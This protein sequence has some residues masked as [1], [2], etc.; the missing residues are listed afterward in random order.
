MTSHEAIAQLQELQSNG[1]IENAHII[2]DKILCDL[3]K[4][5]GYSDVVLEW[6]NVE[7]WY[8]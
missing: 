7:K 8:A 6:K 3:L 5:L 2:A 1:D 4:D